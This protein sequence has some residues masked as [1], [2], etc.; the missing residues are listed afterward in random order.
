MSDFFV[1]WVVI[2]TYFLPQRLQSLPLTQFSKASKHKSWIHKRKPENVN[3]L[4]LLLE[5]SLSK[6][7][8][9]QCISLSRQNLSFV[10][11][12]NL[13]LPLQNL[14]LSKTKK[15]LFKHVNLARKGQN[16]IWRHSFWLYSKQGACGERKH[17]DFS[18]KKERKKKNPEKN[19]DSAPG[20]ITC[21]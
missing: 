10:C 15:S 12:I 17:V 16:M 21:V 20:F 14:I 11:P 18:G 2:L 9:Q 6:S 4:L 7:A 19:V 13:C 8:R 5:P 1:S 3:T